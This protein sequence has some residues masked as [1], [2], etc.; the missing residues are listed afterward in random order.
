MIKTLKK[1]FITVAMAA[2]SVLLIVLIGA[3]NTVN[4]LAADH[5]TTRLLEIL[6]ENGGMFPEKRPEGGKEK[7]PVRF[8]DLL[9]E[10]GRE[11]SSGFF[12]V[13]MDEA[14]EVVFCDV[15]RMISVT[16]EDAEAYAQYVIKSDKRSGKIHHF[17]W[18]TSDTGANGETIAV[19][20][21]ISGQVRLEWKVFL[22]SLLIGVLC[23][24]F[25]FLFIFLLAE[26]AIRPI[27]ENI[28]RQKQFVTDAGHEI[29]T[30]L[31]IIMANTDALELH[32]EET[33]WSRNI[34]TQT[35]RL[36][37]LMQNLLTLSRMDEGAA[38]IS[39][40]VFNLS[41]L[42]EATAQSFRA[43]AEKREISLASKVESDIF[44]EADREQIEQLISILL[45]NAV[46]YTNPGGRI[47]MELNS[48]EYTVSLRLKNTYD[49]ITEEDPE[50][51]FDRFYRGDS[52]RTQ[53]SGGYG[54]G[55]SVARAIVQAYK[56]DIRA[57][58][59]DSGNVV[60]T[61]HLK[62]L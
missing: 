1:K 2:V 50:K 53:K 15:S 14:G 4:Y 30:P 34:R 36:S 13:R 40:S 19:F 31:A 17:R 59:E 41:D 5:Q 42:A 46:N 12:T 45:D 43:F 55:L 49:K 38:K 26:R 23:W 9:P 7:R 20:A 44:I 27:A 25:M 62:C 58:Y 8:S 48:R 61:V 29:K 6:S 39:R 32:S 60:F 28:Q 11:P 37:G 10:D 35:E 16:E 3:I 18:M 21:D 54:V 33:R 51:W 47:E 57:E 56:G 52:A 22:V 24:I